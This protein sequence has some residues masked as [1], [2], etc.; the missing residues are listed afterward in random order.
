MEIVVAARAAVELRTRIF[1]VFL[2]SYKVGIFHVFSVFFSA[3]RIGDN[4][5][6]FILGK[7]DDFFCVVYFFVARD[8][9]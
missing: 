2:V 9:K 3:K 8:S 5:T 6:P 1:A 4:T 7:Q